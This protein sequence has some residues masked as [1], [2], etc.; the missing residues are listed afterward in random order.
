M[1]G[2]SVC[3]RGGAG[4]STMRCGG[5]P[6]SIGRPPFPIRRSFERWMGSRRPSGDHLNAERAGWRRE[7]R[8]IWADGGLATIR[9]K[10]VR[11]Y[12]LGRMAANPATCGHSDGIPFAHIL[13]MKKPLTFPT[14]GRSGDRGVHFFIE[15]ALWGMELFVFS[16]DGP[17]WTEEA[18]WLR[19]R[20]ARPS[21]VPCSRRPAAARSRYSSRTCRGP[22]LRAWMR[23]EINYML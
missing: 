9:S 11:K 5:T 4:R 2:D 23:R 13:R 3:A 8:R 7:P 16:T 10:S 17:R 18:R 12:R 20:E 6:L 1:C 19:E 22:R 14:D 15:W 21:A